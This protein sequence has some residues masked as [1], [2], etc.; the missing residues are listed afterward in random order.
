MNSSLMA[1]VKKA[2]TGEVNDLVDPFVQV[3]FAGLTVIAL[4]QWVWLATHFYFIHA[5]CYIIGIILVIF[6]F[7]LVYPLPGLQQ[8]LVLLRLSMQIVFLLNFIALFPSFNK[9]FFIIFEITFSVFPYF[10]YK[11][12]KMITS[13]VNYNLIFNLRA[14]PALKNTVTHPCGMNRSCSP[15][16]SLR[17]VN[18]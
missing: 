16:C 7:Y 13:S 11:Q 14:K 18:A 3:S 8:S 15:K 2:F 12:K 6:A 4:I 1:N 10:P 5:Y 17:C 9:I